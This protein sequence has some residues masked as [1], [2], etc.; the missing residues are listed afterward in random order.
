MVISVITAAV[1]VTLC[2][3][4]A[5]AYM[6]GWLP[7]RSGIATPLSMASPGQQAAGTAPGVAL[8][9]GETLVTPEAPPPAAPAAPATPRPSTPNYART[10]PS[11]APVPRDPQPEPTTRPEPTPRPSAPAAKAPAY[12]RAAPQTSVC[13]NCGTVTATTANSDSWEVRVRFEDGATQTFRYRTRPDFRTGERVRLEDD[14]L[15]RDR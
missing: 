7:A 12:A 4:V 9:P 1:A 2:A 14:R 15:V 10:A 13:V 8:L 5:I 11:A 6:L 3:L